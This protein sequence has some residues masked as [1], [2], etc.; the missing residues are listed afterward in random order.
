[1]RLHDKF[2]KQIAD[3]EARLRAISEDDSDLPYHSGSWSRKQLLG[4]LIDSA[5]NNH[6]R[7]VG[8]SL[9]NE[10]NGPQYDQEGWVRCHHYECVP[11]TD[12]VSWWSVL[13]QMIIRVVRYTAQEQYAV[14][15]F[16]EG[17]PVMSLEALMEDYLQHMQHHL[18]QMLS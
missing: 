3:A 7:F 8:A 16:I 1:M 9:Q 10:Y 14:P 6:V 5:A 13:N 12:L 18:E 15:C 11:W 2:C 17:V 4:H